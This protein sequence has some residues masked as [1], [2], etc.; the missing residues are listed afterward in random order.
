MTSCAQQIVS[1]G[2]A[3]PAMVMKQGTKTLHGLMPQLA[4]EPVPAAANA[5]EFYS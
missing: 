5:E 4:L 1:K 3:E 2:K